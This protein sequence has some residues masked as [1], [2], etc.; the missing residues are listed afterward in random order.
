[1]SYDVFHLSYIISS[2]GMWKIPHYLRSCNN[3]KYTHTLHRRGNE[4]YLSSKSSDRY[5][6]LVN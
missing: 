1:M 6:H 5:F 2:M 4:F 3:E